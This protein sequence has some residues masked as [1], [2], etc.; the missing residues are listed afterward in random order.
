LAGLAAG[1]AIDR[2]RE[3]SLRVA[4]GGS[5]WTLVRLLA[6]EHAIVVAAGTLAGLSVAPS[7]L[8]AA[9]SLLPPGLMLLLT[10]A[11]SGRVVAFG[12]GSAVLAVAIVTAWSVRSA[13]TAGVRPVLAEAGGATPRARS[14]G[15]AFLIAGQV[16]VA[17]ILALGGALLAASL[18][19][20]SHEDPGFETERRAKIRVNTPGTFSLDRMNGLLDAIAHV[21]GVQAVAG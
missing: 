16:A 14:R 5:T 19:R 12:V 8:S 6:K 21:P 18:V 1:R 11:I 9:V 4:L 20:V 15:R 17:L 7:L 2:Q 10:P 3:L 13:L